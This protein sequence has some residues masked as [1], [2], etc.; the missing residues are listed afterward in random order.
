MNLNLCNTNI[1][2]DMSSFLEYQNIII[3]FLIILTI[4]TAIISYIYL[5]KK[6]LK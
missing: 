1:T 3:T 4:I 5:S 6:E 2:C